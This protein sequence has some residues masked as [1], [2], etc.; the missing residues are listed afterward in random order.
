MTEWAANAG[1]FDFG[2]RSADPIGRVRPLY[3][4]RDFEHRM[5]L[6]DGLTYLPDDILTKIDRAAMAV[7]LETRVPLLDH[8]LAEFAWRLPLATKIRGRTINGHCGKYCIVMCLP[9]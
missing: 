2:S 5:M 7:G 6:L 8:R 9:H 1:P 3:Q 4:V